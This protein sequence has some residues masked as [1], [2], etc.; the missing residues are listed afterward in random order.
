ML[1]IQISQD[2][3]AIDLRQAGQGRFFTASSAVHR[4]KH[5]SE[6]IIIK[7]GRQLRKLSRKNCVGVFLD[8]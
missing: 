4:K 3:A 7:I 2:S 5:N 8:S 6:I 1:N